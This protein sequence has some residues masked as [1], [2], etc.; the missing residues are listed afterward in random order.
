LK[1]GGAVASEEDIQQSKV[2]K[3]A[4]VFMM[5]DSASLLPTVADRVS[6]DTARSWCNE[7]N[8]KWLDMS[9]QPNLKALIDVQDKSTL[10]ARYH[11]VEWVRAGEACSG[12]FLGDW[13]VTAESLGDP[14]FIATLPDDPNPAF[15]DAEASESGIYEVRVH[16]MGKEHVVIVDDFVPAIDGKP[17]SACSKSGM[18]W[19]LIYEKA[20]AKV[21]G[22]YQALSSLRHN[23]ATADASISLDQPVA[24]IQNSRRDAEIGNFTAPAV[25]AA[26]LAGFGDDLSR[27]ASYF[28]E[29][30]YNPEPLEKEPVPLTLGAFKTTQFALRAPAKILKINADTTV[31]I[32]CSYSQETSGQCQVT[33]CLFEMAHHPPPFDPQDPKWRMI[34]GNTSQF[35]QKSVV[36]ETRLEAQSGFP[37][38]VVVGTP[39]NNGEG[40]PDLK[41]EILADNDTVEISDA[42]V[43]E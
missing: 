10:P 23:E 36:I 15:T 5:D 11:D 42:I 27:F 38:L 21:A 37:Y 43:A 14:F 35:G 12:A 13:D 4:G 30:T 22:S 18:M 33:V 7:N 26:T 29:Q 31:H 24:L 25:A 20:C 1:A 16:F 34:S 8:T 32:E 41:L 28:S 9:F 2:N 19:P 39:V 3:D 17:I 40:E 6:L